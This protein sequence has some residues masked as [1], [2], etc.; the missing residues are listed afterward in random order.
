MSN[1]NAYY[2]ERQKKF[3][4]PVYG[5]DYKAFATAANKSLIENPV[6]MNEPSP[7]QKY[8]RQLEQSTFTKH[9][10]KGGKTKRK[11]RQSKSRR[12]RK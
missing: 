9:S 2:N 1:D 8:L 11:R 7:Y 10:K 6:N 5:T 4:D 12:I 3:S